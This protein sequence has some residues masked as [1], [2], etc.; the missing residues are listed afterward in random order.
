MNVAFIL[1]YVLYLKFDWYTKAMVKQSCTFQTNKTATQSNL[2][3][4]DTKQKAFYNLK[5]Y[6][7]FA[8]S[9]TSKYNN[10]LLKII[11]NPITSWHTGAYILLNTLRLKFK[12][13]KMN[14][15]FF[16]TSIK[17]FT[18]LFIAIFETCR[19]KLSLWVFLL[20][21]EMYKWF[22]WARRWT[23][24]WIAL[25]F[26]VPWQSWAGRRPSP[27]R[28]PSASGWESRPSSLVEERVMEI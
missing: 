10:Q 8:L 1:F 4:T 2:F 26:P 28:T 19:L 25:S 15:Y 18:R 14:Q 22:S 3:K 20:V 5:T 11:S 21:C 7:R 27:P 9:T 13:T 6:K 23:L 16:L 24:T 17:N 12:H